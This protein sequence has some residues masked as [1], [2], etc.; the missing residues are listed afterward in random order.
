MPRRGNGDGSVRLRPN[1][2][3]QG[4]QPYIDELGR[5]RRKYFTGAT[6]RDVDALKKK[7]QRG[8]DAGQPADPSTQPLSEYLTAWLEGDARR[9]LR[10]HVL[11]GYEAYIRLHIS[12]ILGHVP[13]GSLTTKHVQIM[14]DEL[15]AGGKLAHSSLA[16][17]RGV[18]QSALT[19][20]KRRGLVAANE[21]HGVRVPAPNRVEMQ[22]WHPQQIRKFLNSLHGHPMEAFYV[23]SLT[24]GW[25]LGE[26]L[27]L[28]WQDISFERGTVSIV[29]A[30]ERSSTSHNPVFT[31]TKNRY[32]RRTVSLSQAAVTALQLHSTHQKILQEIAGEN[33]GNKWDLVFTSSTGLP[34][35]QTNISRQF[36]LLT[37]QAKLPLIRVH[38]MRHTAA[39]AMIF[40][41]INIKVISATLGHS[42]IRIT[43]DTYGHL[44]DEQKRAVA[45]AMDDLLA[46]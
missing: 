20:A 33:W 44:L 39:T 11:E 46:G 37:E 41:G 43:L 3:Y 4:Y 23:C 17:V 16:R 14:I 29:Q 2:T 13:L 6:K 8:L 32:S 12:P 1:G 15:E 22:Y 27:G 25:R 7:F 26:G 40:A 36:K 24:L 35:A 21:A 9:H 45:D 10:P 28:R 5:K 31:P 18:L 38:D 19:D 30:L 42:S 34:L